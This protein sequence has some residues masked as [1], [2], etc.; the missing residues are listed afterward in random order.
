MDVTTGRPRNR[1]CHALAQQRASCA[2]LSNIFFPC[3]LTR[4]VTNKL[5]IFERQVGLSIK[6]QKK[7]QTC[8]NSRHFKI[9]KDAVFEL[10]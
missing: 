5:K 8:S 1:Y 2:D 7:F 3:K 9:I 4:Q 6:F 10:I